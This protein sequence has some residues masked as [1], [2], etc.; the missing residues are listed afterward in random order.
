MTAEKALAT[1]DGRPYFERVLTHALARGLLDATRLAGLRRE[2]A[3][4]IVQLASHFGT[5]NL[6]PELEAARTRLITLV[7]LALEAE[8]GGRIEV[9]AALLVDKTLLALS[10]AGADRLRA[11]LKLPMDSFLEPVH[12]PATDEKPFLAR[13]TFDEPITFARYLA[14]KR[15]REN[16]QALHELTYALAAHF[17][18]TRKDVQGWHT[19]CESVLNS[20]L[21]VLYA[22]KKPQGF[23]G[24]ERFARLHGAA[25][26]KRKAD[27]SL[28]EEWR[29]DLPPASQRLLDRATS[30]FLNETLELVKRH[31]AADIYRDQDRFSGVFFFDVSDVDEVTHHDRAAEEVWRRVTGGKGDHPDVQCTVLLLLAT[32][33]APAPQLRKKDA[34]AVWQ[35]YR[36]SGFNE[37]AVRSFIENVVPFEYQGDILRLWESDLAPEARA[38]LEETDQTRALRYLHETCRPAWKGSPQ[39]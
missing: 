13:W 3:K 37:T 26:R 1:V 33:Q 18:A 24:G 38:S 31:D 35:V 19:S 30:R 34:L 22:E 15:H 23:F 9:A 16:N 29:A 11:I 8:S 14:E 2:G 25:C 5:A 6:R 17:G 36:E 39:R 28:L 27:F 32:G 21:L 12:S 20:I 7:G 4:A 10:K